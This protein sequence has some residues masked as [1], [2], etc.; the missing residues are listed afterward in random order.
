MNEDNRAAQ[1]HRTLKGARIVIN[2]GFSTFDCTI[3]NLSGTGAKLQVASA[4]GIP[5]RFGLKL[6][7]GRQFSC[8]TAWRT[9][10]EIGVRFL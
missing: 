4:L 1:R 8:E 2:D 9:D 3:R 5:E 7:D 10:T 6:E